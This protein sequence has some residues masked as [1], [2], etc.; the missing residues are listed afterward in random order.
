MKYK[1]LGDKVYLRVDKGEEVVASICKTCEDLHIASATFHGIGGC[2]QAIVATYIPD[3]HDFD[4][5]VK[6]GM[7]EMTSLL[8]NLIQEES[9]EQ[10][11]HAHATFSFLDE[12]GQVTMFGGHLKST[13]IL[14]TGEFVI[15][16]VQGG[17]IR[18]EWD[19]KEGIKVWKLP[20]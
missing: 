1:Q 2:S 10:I 9:G 3:K 19:S 7:L 14:Y 18:D 20:D 4:D 5:H 6:N 16:P 15:E 8:G 12:E 17:I 11:F 13:T